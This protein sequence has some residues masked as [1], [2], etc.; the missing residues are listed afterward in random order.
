MGVP[1]FSCQCPTWV[2]AK[3]GSCEVPRRSSSADW[4]ESQRDVD[5]LQ[6]MAGSQ[7]S[8]QA[9]GSSAESDSGPR[10]SGAAVGPW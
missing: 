9:V 4:W 2:P 6:E 10:P 8:V 1:G 3:G 7:P 5:G